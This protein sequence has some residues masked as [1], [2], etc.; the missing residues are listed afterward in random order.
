MT[1]P[2]TAFDARG[3]QLPVVVIVPFGQTTLVTDPKP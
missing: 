2:D 1:S 3:L